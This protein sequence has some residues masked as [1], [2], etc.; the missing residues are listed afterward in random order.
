MEVKSSKFR[1]SFN[2]S[3][4]SLEKDKFMNPVEKTDTKRLYSRN[5]AS[6]RPMLKILQDCERNITE[7]IIFQCKRLNPDFDSKIDSNDYNGAFIKIL[8]KAVDL[9]LFYQSKDCIALIE[10]F[11]QRMAELNSLL[12]EA[13]QREKTE[14]AKEKKLI[15]R[16]KVIEDEEK[17][18]K[19]KLIILSENAE[20]SALKK[21]YF[22][23]KQELK[24]AKEELCQVKTDNFNKDAIIKQ[25][26]AHN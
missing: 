16:E 13:Y 18:S 14:K 25:L 8:K 6:P 26:L 2:N 23:V 4:K 11:K 17:N 22:Q 24:A 5:L 21:G 9:V 19:E 10:N 1:F 7:E 20:I 3:K 12:E 15:I